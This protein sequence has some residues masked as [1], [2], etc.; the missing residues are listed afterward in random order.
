ME[1][2]PKN[3]NGLGTKPSTK[4]QLKLMTDSLRIVEW[5]IKIEGENDAPVI[6][7]RQILV[8]SGLD[9]VTT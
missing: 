1:I 8:D 4:L 2:H 5:N 6:E 3:I 9:G 7:T